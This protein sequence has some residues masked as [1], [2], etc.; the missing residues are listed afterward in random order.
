MLEEARDPRVQKDT[1]GHERRRALAG[2]QV[3][4]TA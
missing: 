4:E 2:T 3:V 1:V